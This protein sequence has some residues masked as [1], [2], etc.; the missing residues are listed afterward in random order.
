[1]ED[2]TLEAT[3]FDGMFSGRQPRQDIK[4]DGPV[5]AEVVA[6]PRYQYHP[7]DGDG[8]IPWNVVESSPLNAACPPE[9]ISMYWISW[10][11]LGSLKDEMLK[12]L[13]R[14]RTK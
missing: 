13:I 7:E 10:F 12:S 9:I 6:L 8:V 14:L 2:I 11:H 1:M 3:G 4:V 5:E